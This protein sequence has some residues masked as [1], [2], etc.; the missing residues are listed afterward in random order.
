MGLAKL[1]Q[2]VWASPTMPELMASMPISGQDGT[3]RRAK[4]TAAAHLKTGSLRNVLG[5]AGFVDGQQGQR[6]VMVAIIEHP[7]A[8]GGRP[9]LDQL[10]TWVASLPHHQP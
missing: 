10:T 1:L 8:Q 7:Q 5:V 4:S 3:L 6:W 2:H 9:A